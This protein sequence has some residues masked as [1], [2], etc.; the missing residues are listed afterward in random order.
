MWKVFLPGTAILLAISVVSGIAVAQD[1]DQALQSLLDEAGAAQSGGNF[2]E[3]ANAYR[4]AVVLEPAAPKLWA[5]LGLME[6]ESGNHPEAIRSLQQAAR[7]NP[8]LF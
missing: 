2:A 4:K 5:N 1:H 7:L 6:H 3:A 8:S